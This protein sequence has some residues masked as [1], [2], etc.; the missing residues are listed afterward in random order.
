MDLGSRLK[1]KNKS[2]ELFAT[3][4]TI[5]MHMVSGPAVGFGIGYALDAWLGTNPWFKLAFFIIGIGAG[6]LNVYE[7]SKRLLRK[8]NNQQPGSGHGPRHVP[9]HVPSHVSSDTKENSDSGAEGSIDS[10]AESNAHA[11]IKERGES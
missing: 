1:A 3:A 2:M 8:M 11:P 5:G 4:G 6:F 7:D 9:S 10:G